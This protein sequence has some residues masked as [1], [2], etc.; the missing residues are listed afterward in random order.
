M[1][2][3]KLKSEDADHFFKAIL[4]LETEEECYRFFEDVCTIGELRS[5]AQRFAVARL[6]DE[7]VTY[8]A[9]V[10]STNASTATI[11]RVNKC[12]TYGAE[13]YRLALD[14]LKKEKNSI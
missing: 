3:S 12:L 13:G 1:Y 14:R 8:N 9:I 4:S 6:L 5:I 2:N 7:G 11:S 10:D